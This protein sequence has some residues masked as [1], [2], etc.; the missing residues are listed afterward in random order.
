MKTRTKTENK[1]NDKRQP[2]Y[3]DIVRRKQEQVKRRLADYLS[4]RINQLSPRHRKVVLIASGLLIAA[5]CF[6]LV[7]GPGE[8]NVSFGA[9]RRTITPPPATADSAGISTAPDTI[10]HRP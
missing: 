7:F 8:F 3:F 2:D 4:N 10:T 6:R 9:I 1:T 5:L